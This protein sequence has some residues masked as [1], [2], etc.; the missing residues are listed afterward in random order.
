L[1]CR[2]TL[3][4]GAIG[5]DSVVNMIGICPNGFE[6]MSGEESRRQWIMTVASLG[7]RVGWSRPASPEAGY[8]YNER[9]S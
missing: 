7:E 6:S 5:C 3:A 1:A 9:R 2:N 8:E 4:S